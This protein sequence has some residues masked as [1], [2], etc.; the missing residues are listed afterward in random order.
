MGRAPGR[1]VPDGR[2]SPELRRFARVRD[3]RG[4]QGDRPGLAA[5]LAAQ[6]P[7]DPADTDAPG[8]SDSRAVNL[9]LAAITAVV[10]GGGGGR[11]TARAAPGA[12]L[13]R[14]VGLL[15]SR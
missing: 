2:S 15:R 6:Y 7:R 10:V 5:L 14:V 1:A 13:R 12:V 11:V 8:A 3:R 4:R 9:A